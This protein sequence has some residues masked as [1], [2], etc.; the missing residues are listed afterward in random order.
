MLALLRVCLERNFTGPCN[1][2]HV[3]KA[4]LQK[5]VQSPARNT[6]PGFVLGDVLRF[7]LWRPRSCTRMLRGQMETGER[8]SRPQVI[9]LA[10]LKAEKIP[11]NFLLFT[12]SLIFAVL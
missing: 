1:A 7:L 5:C 6:A 8:Y 3:E 2:T 10:Q 9:L 12:G 11:V 4:I